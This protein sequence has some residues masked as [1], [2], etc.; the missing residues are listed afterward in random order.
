MEREGGGGAVG[1]GGLED[2]GQV[3]AGEEV[4]VRELVVELRGQVVGVLV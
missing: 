4:V 1:G 2:V 3:E